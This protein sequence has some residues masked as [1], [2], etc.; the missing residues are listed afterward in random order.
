MTTPPPQYINAHHKSSLPRLVLR[1][2]ESPKGKLT[3]RSF[4][5][6]AEVILTHQTCGPS[7]SGPKDPHIPRV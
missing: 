7:L 2:T 3:C 6:A 1:L 4:H 5:E